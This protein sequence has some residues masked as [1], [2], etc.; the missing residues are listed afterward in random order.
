MKKI[1][2][3]SGTLEY[4]SS[5]TKS[6]EQIDLS[7]KLTGR[8]VKVTPTMDPCADYEI[9]IKINDQ[10][11]T[12]KNPTKDYSDKKVK[13]SNDFYTEQFKPTFSQDD[14]SKITISWDKF[15]LE[16]TVQIYD[17]ESS[18]VCETQDS[19]CSVEALNPCDLN[20]YSVNK[21]Y[22]SYHLVI[23]L[24]KDTHLLIR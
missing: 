12:V 7:L 20:E 16:T 6:W 22:T 15:C 1:F 9:K 24:N 17:E 18:I 10:S 13:F 19:S 14:D 23:Y 21:T 3:L 2:L 5:I 8:K 4:R 11:L